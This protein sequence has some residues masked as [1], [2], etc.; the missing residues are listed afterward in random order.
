MRHFFKYAFRW[1]FYT[2]ALALC[3]A[4][5]PGGAL[6]QAVLINVLVA[7]FFYHADTRV[8]KR[9]THLSKKRSIDQE[10]IPY[11]F[12]TIAKNKIRFWK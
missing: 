6:L 11:S 7:V 12:V 10:F 5:I 2:P 8:L 3:I 1:Q 9:K 4:V